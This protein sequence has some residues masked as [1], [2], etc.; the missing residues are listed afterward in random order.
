MV[1]DHRQQQQWHRCGE[2]HR[3]PAE[4][5]QH[6]DTD[7][8]REHAAQRVATEHDRHQRAAQALGRVFVHQ[9]HGVGHQ[10][11]TAQ[12][13]DKAVDAKLAGA[14]G[15]TVEDGRPGEQGETDG[16]ALL[17]PDAVG[18][19][20][21]GQGAEHHAEQR[22]AAQRTGLQRGQ[23]PLFHDDR[24]YH[25]VDE[26]VIA[27]EDQQQA[28]PGHDH[29]VERGKARVIDDRV[30]VKGSHGICRSCFCC[31]RKLFALWVSLSRG[32][33]PLPARSRR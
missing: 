17:A 16:D 8:R 15:K 6:E 5:R 20:A 7:T 28:A 30:Y 9:R 33:R 24:Q 3:F 29:P 25:A 27:V 2:E 10:A 12:A 31:E 22:I 26:Q 1:E 32:R 11:A 13:G 18:Q 21:E 4:T 14:A 19:A 23:P